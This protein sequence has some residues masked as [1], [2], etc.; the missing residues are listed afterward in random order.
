MRLLN[1]DTFTFTDFFGTSPPPYV[2]ASHRWIAGA[3]AMWE[4]IQEKKRTD[5]VGYRK[6][7]GFIEYMK[8]HLPLIKWLWIDTCC[9]KQHADRELSA[10]INSMFR[11][12]Q[13]AEVCLA[14]MED[15]P[16]VDDMA[17]FE[18]SVWFQRGW[19]L[20]ELLAPSMVVFLSRDWN[21]IG[22]KG[23][24]GHGRSGM[25]ISTGP[26]LEDRISTVT[27]IP[28]VILHDYGASENLSPEDKMKWVEGRDT[29]V[30]EDL[31][32]CL[33][34]I[35]GV[36]MNVRYGV[37]GDETRAR[38]LR[39]IAKRKGIAAPSEYSVPFNLRSIPASAHFVPRDVVT[40][41]LF[42]YFFPTAAAAPEQQRVFVVYG[43]GGIGKTQLCADFARSN[44]QRFSAVFWL[45]G[46]SKESLQ[47]SMA[48]AAMQLP[49]WNEGTAPTDIVLLR[50]ALLN[51]LSLPGNTKWL[52]I[53]DNID[54]DWQ[55]Q[56]KDEQAYNYRDF[57]PSADHG[58][59]LIT[60]R[61]SR[62]QRPNACLNLKS[63]DDELARKMIES[64]A[65][66]PVEG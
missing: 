24:S 42:D 2:I 27:K 11:W 4:D 35:L 23:S 52:V 49:L 16:R 13:Q 62:L 45:D 39:K 55:T 40:Q 56:P 28:Q 37:G 20:Q 47:R 50:N 58:N 5:T 36:D 54:R 21:I 30:P 51:W 41:R 29:T 19:T 1:V 25:S 12:Y 33:L 31:S 26:S 46:D 9:I 3:E 17:A 44:A 63:V 64:R 43:M 14:Y 7:Q 57:L 66:K 48:N 8:A 15:V 65:G 34:G 61:L 22:H 59:V 32:Y 38:L 53:M 60:T 18:S 10:A 6:V